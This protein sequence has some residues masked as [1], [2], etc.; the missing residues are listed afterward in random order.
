LFSASV[1]TA[2]AGEGAAAI[3]ITAGVPAGA[4]ATFISRACH[5]VL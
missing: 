2:E 4:A 1:L 3:S 5:L